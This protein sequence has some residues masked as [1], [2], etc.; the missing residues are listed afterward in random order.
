MVT[1]NSPYSTS[2]K[3]VYL[4]ELS[5]DLDTGI[6]DCLDPRAY[7]AKFKTYTPDNPS[8]NMAM[9]G[10]DA[11]KWGKAMIIE[12]KG[13][14]KQKTWINVDRKSVPTNKPILPRTWTF[15][16]KRLPDGPPLKYKA[17]YCVRGDNQVAGVDYIETYAPVVQWSTIQLVLTMVWGNG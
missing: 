4:A 2:A 16:L 9:S 12:I 8:F 14:L 7:A 5:T 15:K 10:E 1:P 17:R 6:I 11:H 3:L 13:I